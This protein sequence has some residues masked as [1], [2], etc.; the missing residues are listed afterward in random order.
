MKNNIFIAIIAAFLAVAI[1]GATFTIYNKVKGSPVEPEAETPNTEDEN[2]AELKL[3]TVRSEGVALSFMKLS[4][5]SV[6][7]ATAATN[8]F[9]SKTITATVLPADAPD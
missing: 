8:N 1:I 9:L 2:V 4:D 6:P 5:S 7:E 3:D